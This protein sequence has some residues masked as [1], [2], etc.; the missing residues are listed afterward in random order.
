MGIPTQLQVA[1]TP[2]MS[3]DDCAAIWGR[4][5]ITDRMQ[6]VGGTGENSGCQGDSG[7]PLAYQDP[8]DGDHPTAKLICQQSGP[9]TSSSMTGSNLSSLKLKY[10][11]H[12]RYFISFIVKNTFMK[13]YI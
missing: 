5:R 13:I 10:D 2:L 9:R 1:T 11:T 7:G 3:Q 12:Y 6:C 4:L 8:P